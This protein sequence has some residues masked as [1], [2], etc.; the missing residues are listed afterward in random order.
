MVSSANFRSLAVSTQGKELRGKDVALR[1]T[2]GAG[3][4]V[5]DVLPQLHM[6]LPVRQEVIRHVQLG[7]LVLKNNV[8]YNVL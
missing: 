1:G 4:L 6:L 7:E 5:R 8:L 3:P 2:G